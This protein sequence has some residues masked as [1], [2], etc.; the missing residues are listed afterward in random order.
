MYNNLEFKGTF[1]VPNVNL[2]GV[3]YSLEGRIGQVLGTIFNLGSIETLHIVSITFD[4]LYMTLN[5][6]DVECITIDVSVCNSI[7]HEYLFNANR[8]LRSGSGD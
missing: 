3:N 5:V 4:Q 6:L 7:L 8:H 2:L 1:D